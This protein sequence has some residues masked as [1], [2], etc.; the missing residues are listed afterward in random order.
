MSFTIPGAGELRPA[1]RPAAGE[2]ANV[3]GLL[4]GSD[5]AL[6]AETIAYSGTLITT[7]RR[8]GFSTG[9]R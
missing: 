3:I 2:S 4:E 7:H 9:G 6:K 5:P 1:C 8:R